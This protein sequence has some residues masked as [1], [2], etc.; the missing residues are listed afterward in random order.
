MIGVSILSRGTEFWWETY[1]SF[2]SLTR[3]SLLSIERRGLDCRILTQLQSQRMM[4]PLSTSNY[5]TCSIKIASLNVGLV[6]YLLPF[7]CAYSIPVLPTLLDDIQDRM[8]GW[9]KEGRM[10]PFTDIYN[11]SHSRSISCTDG[12]SSIQARFPND[13][14]DGELSRARD[15]Y[16]S[17]GQTS[18]RLLDDGKERDSDCPFAPLVS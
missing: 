15:E 17:R 2:S 14:S 9:G 11:V 10:D 3:N 1:V 18:T 5:C 13:R 6:L 8:E 4:Y 16:S 12:V 7:K